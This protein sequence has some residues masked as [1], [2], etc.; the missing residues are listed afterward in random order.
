MSLLKQLICFS[1]VFLLVAVSFLFF[2]FQDS[3]LQGF[4]NRGFIASTPASAARALLA[5]AKEKVFQNGCQF[6]IYH[7]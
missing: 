2:F 7:L 4:G 1:L 3:V 6:H 5:I